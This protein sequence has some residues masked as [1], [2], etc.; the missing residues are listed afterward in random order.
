METSLSREA[1]LQRLADLEAELAAYR[2]NATNG[3]AVAELGL[4]EF[5]HTADG[6]CV[7]HAIEAFPFVHFT[8]W[9]RR[10]VE[11]TGYD[12]A[13]INRKG[14]Y[15]SVYPDPEVQARAIER[16]SQ[17][18]AG[19][20]LDAET[21]EIT[22]ADGDTRFVRIS[23]SVLDQDD[24]TPRV[25]AIM[26][27]VS[28]W[29][30]NEGALERERR[31]LQRQIH[32]QA[33]RLAAAEQA[34]TI[35]DARYRA[36]FEIAGDALFVEDDQD[37]ILDVNQRACDLLG[38]D[39][40]ELVT[41][42]VADIQAPECRGQQGRILIEEAVNYRGKPFETVDLHKDGTRIPVEVTNTRLEEAGL[43][44]SIVRDIRPRQAAEQA[45]RETFAIIEA[46]PVVVFLWRNEAHW[47]VEFVTAN[48]AH[49]F[50]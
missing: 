46:S 2:E 43:F 26:H 18:R 34:L 4:S 42:T 21:W 31:S 8:F 39:R 41:K 44:L 3:N 48:V 49:L 15:Q 27:D 32:R 29:R 19:V 20:N 33:E 6:I 40:E 1:L 16:M 50:G 38:Y 22:R 17:M 12:R 5:E 25:M 9:N 11:L 10:M 30:R 7:C 24:E 14:W 36:L 13:T 45:R 35:S 28:A 23:T 37:R 47:P